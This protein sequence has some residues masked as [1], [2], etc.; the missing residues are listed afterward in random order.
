MID[1]EQCSGEREG[2][3]ASEGQPLWS[4]APR[5]A[6][7]AEE[8][9]AE[10]RLWAEADPGV[11]R[12]RGARPFL[13]ATPFGGLSQPARGCTSVWWGALRTPGEH[14]WT[15]GSIV[16]PWGAPLDP[17]EHRWTPGGQW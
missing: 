14:R 17:G 2:W 7:R 8:M 9:G 5:S 16:D 12:G 4:E 3:G 10:T 13:C 15:L 11:T 1:L 6:L